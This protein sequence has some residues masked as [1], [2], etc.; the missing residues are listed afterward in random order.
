MKKAY[1]L[2][3]FIILSSFSICKAQYNY[4]PGYAILNDGT[5]I[6]GMIRFFD[7]EPWFNQ[8]F[9]RIKDSADVAKNPNVGAKRLK[10]DDL[11]YYEVVSR[12]FDKLHYVDMENLQLKS[13]GTN[14]HMMER[15]CTGRIVAHRFYQYPPDT[16]GYIGTEE[17]F[18]RKEEQEKEDLRQGYKIL[19]QKDNDSKLQNAFDVDL[20]KYFGDT[21]EVWEKYKSGGYGNQPIV[22]RGLAGRMIAM[23]KKQA[24]RKEEAEAIIAAINDYNAKNVAK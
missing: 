5:R 8:R 16:E 18:K 4:Q 11:K 12:K 20:Q 19:I 10:A 13:L 17:E 7:N 6:S 2:L 22:K 14:D 21:P 15:L 1:N 3:L 9:I 23:A 24:F